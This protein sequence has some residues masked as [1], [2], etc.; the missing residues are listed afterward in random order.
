M[1]MCISFVYWHRKYTE[2][3]T[4]KL[5]W[6]IFCTNY[7]NELTTFRFMMH[8]FIT[9]HNTSPKFYYRTQQ[10][11]IQKYTSE[12]IKTISQV[13]LSLLLY[14]CTL[15]IFFWCFSLIEILLRNYFHSIWYKW[16]ILMSELKYYEKKLIC[17]KI[18]N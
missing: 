15:Y 17:E 9:E 4:C 12:H 11:Q 6:T 5:S 18:M 1:Y 13:K 7:S 8:L 2:K 10:S 14:T 3:C 16:K